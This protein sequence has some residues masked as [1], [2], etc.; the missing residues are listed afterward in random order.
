[1]SVARRSL[2]RAR[3]VIS[4]PSSARMR[5]AYVAA[6]SGVACR[7]MNSGQLHPEMYCAIQPRSPG[8]MVSGFDRDVWKV[9][10]NEKNAD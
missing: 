5:A 4:M 7:A 3:T 6:S 8:F 2:H 9:T 1:M 10:L